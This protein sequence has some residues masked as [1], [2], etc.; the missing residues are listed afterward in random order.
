MNAMSTRY[1]GNL[2]ALEGES[3]SRLWGGRGCREK[4]MA[5]GDI[6]R[7][8]KGALIAEAGKPAE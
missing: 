5:L 7:F 2:G 8:D 1:Y 4:Y 6:A 3:H